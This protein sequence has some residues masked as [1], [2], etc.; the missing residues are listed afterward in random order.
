MISSVARFRTK[1]AI[2]SDG[3]K[4][5]RMYSDGEMES[6]IESRE[7]GLEICCKNRREAVPIVLGVVAANFLNLGRESSTWPTFQLDKYV[8]G[9]GDIALDRAVR[10]FDS[11][12][13]NAACKARESL[14][15]GTRV[16]SRKRSRMACVK[17]LEYIESLSAANFAKNYPVG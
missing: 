11:A 1:T 15:G 7:T 8:Q 14:C 12:L 16:D 17:Q 13:E 4:L 3:L 10:Q 5:S 6:G 2:R 9:I